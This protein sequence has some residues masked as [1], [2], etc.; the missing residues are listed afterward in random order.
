MSLALHV[1]IIAHQGKVACSSDLAG[2]SIYVGW[3]SPTHWPART[4]PYVH[5]GH[6]VLKYSGVQGNIV[7][8]QMGNSAAASMDMTPLVEAF[9]NMMSSVPQLQ[10]LFQAQPA[11]QPAQAGQA[12]HGGQAGSGGQAGRRGQAGQD[13][14]GNASTAQPAGRGSCSYSV[15][16]A[17]D[18]Q[19]YRAF[20]A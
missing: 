7:T 14:A 9:E 5:V 20:H 8:I 1:H 17:L 16:I 4:C 18:S 15:S 19:S 10:Q 11:S 12:A 3:C 6:S 13:E 2:T